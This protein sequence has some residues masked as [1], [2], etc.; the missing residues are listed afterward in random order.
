LE[1][2][3]HLGH[4]G[5]GTEVNHSFLPLGIGVIPGRT[6]DYC[7]INRYLTEIKITK[8]ILPTPETKFRIENTSQIKSLGEIIEATGIGIVG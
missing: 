8:D 7:P 4:T 3:F 5:I 2:D 1:L 6:P